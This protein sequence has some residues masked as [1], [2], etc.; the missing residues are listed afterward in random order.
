[1]RGVW[2]WAPRSGPSSR[3]PVLQHPASITVRTVS[4]GVGGPGPPPSLS[5]S[6]ALIVIHS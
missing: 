4:L 1:M 6:I 2:A 3:L 5:P